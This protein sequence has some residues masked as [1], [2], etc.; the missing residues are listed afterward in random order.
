MRYY[1]YISE[2]KVEMLLPQ[3]PLSLKQR[4]SAEIGVDIGI[5]SGRLSAQMDTMDNL[6]ARAQAVENYIIKHEGAGTSINSDK[7]WFYG[8]YSAVILHFDTNSNVVFWMLK[9]PDAIVM[10]G[11][12][13]KHLIGNVSTNS[14]SPSLSFAPDLIEKIYDYRKLLL[15]LPESELE[16]SL[17]VGVSG[18]PWTNLI[19]EVHFMLEG[20]RSMEQRI[21]FLAR[22]LLFDE[23]GEK[24]VVLATPLLVYL[25][26]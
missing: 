21:G 6:V 9:R 1:Q 26:E 25:A 16:S 12:S 3:I 23:I 13:S 7:G 8:E 5:L 10:L 4:I 14:I 24:P 15:R 19:S 17:S 2:A 20:K 22:R 18:K 11:G